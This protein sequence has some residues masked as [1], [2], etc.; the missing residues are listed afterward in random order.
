MCVAGRY[1]LTQAS[2]LHAHANIISRA[3][4]DP[5]TQLPQHARIIIRAL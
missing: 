1:V 3:L 4:F 2:G 5:T